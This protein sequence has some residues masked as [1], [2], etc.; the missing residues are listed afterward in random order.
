MEAL[1]AKERSDFLKQNF[2]EK[3]MFSK[4]QK[5]D[6]DEFS[7]EYKERTSS[8]LYT[9][10][11]YI[12]SIEKIEVGD[13]IKLHQAL[14]YIIANINSDKL[15]LIKINGADPLMEDLIINPLNT[16]AF[17]PNRDIYSAIQAMSMNVSLLI[18]TVPYLT[19]DFGVDSVNIP[20]TELIPYVSLMNTEP[21]EDVF[22]GIYKYKL[23][24]LQLSLEDWHNN[25][26]SAAVLVPTDYLLSEGVIYPF[27]GAILNYSMNSSY[28][29]DDFLSVNAE[30]ETVDDIDDDEP[31]LSNEYVALCTGGLSNSLIYN[32]NVLQ[33]VNKDNGFHPFVGLEEDLWCTVLGHKQNA[34]KELQQ[35]VALLQEKH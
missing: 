8:E 5:I 30:L 35:V 10:G 33:Q 4:L 13:N 7:C 29:I 20:E 18:Y 15:F 25:N 28:P 31:L 17:V 12:R 9:S 19:E 11:E 22:K 3:N 16:Y 24:D 27:F 34:L 2:T 32:L 6:K 26:N 23:P 14:N 21:T 1:I